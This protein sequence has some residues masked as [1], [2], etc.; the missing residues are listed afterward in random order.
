MA[1]LDEF[2]RLF[3]HCR[4]FNSEFEVLNLERCPP[5]PAELGEWFAAELLERGI[6]GPHDTPTV[7]HGDTPD[8]VA[9]GDNGGTDVEV[10]TT[11]SESGYSELHDDDVQADQ[12]VYLT[13]HDYYEHDAPID[14]FHIT[15]PVGLCGESGRQFTR[16][17][18]EK[19]LDP[20]QVWP[21]DL[22]DD[23]DR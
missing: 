21:P 13:C 10:K 6:I 23:D 22:L 4:R 9:V 18:V 3:H 17:W 11:N 14:V 7:L 16:S 2:G 19:R 1:A 15:D 12:A 20:V 8:L 5:I